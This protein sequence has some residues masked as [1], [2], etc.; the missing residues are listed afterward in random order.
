MNTTQPS[1]SCRTPSAI[2]LPQYSTVTPIRPIRKL[3]ISTV[4][5]MVE[6]K[7]TAFFQNGAR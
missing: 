7:I 4:I 1:K 6:R 2:S 5:G 3:F